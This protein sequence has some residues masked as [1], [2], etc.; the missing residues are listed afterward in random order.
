M[1]LTIRQASQLLGCSYVWAYRLYKAGRI[2]LNIRSVKEYKK[3]KR[4]S[5]RPPQIVG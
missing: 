1:K 2:Q 3:N 5:G 4:P